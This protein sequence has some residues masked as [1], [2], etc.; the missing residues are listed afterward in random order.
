[1]AYCAASDVKAYAGISGSGDDTL[2][3]ALIGRAQRAI[4]AYCR[5]TFEAGSDGTRYFDAAANVRGRQ[6]WL[7]Q[8]L[9]QITSVTNGDGSTVAGSAYNVLPYNAVA[10]GRPI[11]ALELKGSAGVA[12]TYEDDAEAAIAIVGRWAYS[13][14]A[15]ADIV[16]ATVRLATYLYRQKDNAGDLDRPV[17]VGANTTLLPAELPK[18]L[19]QFL[20]PYRR[21]EIV[22]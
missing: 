14:T 20:A 21:W 11:Y 9:A 17:T 19:K 10:N 13:V 1:M 8:D 16:Q 4:D 2:I 5:R 6:L 7:D 12:W 15:P 22:P 18:D 3:T